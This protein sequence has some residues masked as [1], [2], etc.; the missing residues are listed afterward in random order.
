MAVLLV[1]PL[2]APLPATAGPTSITSIQVRYNP[3]DAD[4]E[5]GPNSFVI[6]ASDCPRQWYLQYQW[7]ENAGRIQPKCQGETT[8]VS[9][10]PLGSAEYPLKW[11]SCYIAIWRY[12]PLITPICGSYREDV[13]LTS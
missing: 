6:T 3:G 4:P 11:R 2:T 10:A 12:P 7:G 5:H 9:L 8:V 13:V 1:T